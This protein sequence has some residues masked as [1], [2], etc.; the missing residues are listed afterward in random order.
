MLADDCF[1]GDA[2]LCCELYAALLPYLLTIQAGC[3]DAL[4][5]TLVQVFDF[6]LCLIERYDNLLARKG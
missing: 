4:T 3:L 2:L 6:F 5:G 1:C